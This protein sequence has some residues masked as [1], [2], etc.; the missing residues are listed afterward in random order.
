MSFPTP[1]VQAY[2]KC[3]LYFLK[4]KSEKEAGKIN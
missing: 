4:I 1:Q 3:F 2:L